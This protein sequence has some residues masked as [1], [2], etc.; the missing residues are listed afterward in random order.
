MYPLARD[1]LT[2]RELEKEGLEPHKT[3]E[4]Y[5]ISFDKGEEIVDISKTLDTKIEVLKCHSSQ[6]GPESF[7]WVRQ[8]AE[9]TGKK[10]GYRY[11]EGFIKLSFW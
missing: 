3:K 6:V 10:K 11:A 8:M 5:L 4:L 2:F 1:R 9:I 7:G